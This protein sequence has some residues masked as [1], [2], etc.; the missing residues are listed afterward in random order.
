MPLAFRPGAR[1]R[2]PWP[3]DL[4]LMGAGLMLGRPRGQ[5]GRPGD[6]LV[7]TE[8][9]DLSKVAPT[10]FE[11][12]ATDPEGNR[13]QPYDD[14][15]L[16]F[17]LQTQDA[18]VDRRYGHTLNADVSVPG[19]WLKGP[20]ITTFTPATTDATN[21]VTK[22]FDLGANTY[23]LV[24]RYA[25]LRVSDA[26]WSVSK[27]FGIGIRGRDV[28]TFH[29]NALAAQLAV[30]AIDGAA[31]WHFDGTTWTQFATF[32]SLA[33]AAVGRELYR[34]SDVNLV[35]KV[36]TNADPTNEA[37]WT[38]ANAF[39]VGDKASPIT[40]MFV[41]ATGVL[42]IVKTDG[43]YSLDGAGQDIR[44]FPFL[45]PAPHPDAG[46]GGGAFL[47]DLYLPFR[48]GLYRLA[49]DFVLQEAGPERQH[50][51]AFLAGVRTT[52]FQGHDDLHAYAGVTDETDGYLMKLLPSGVWHGPVSLAFAG[53]RITALWKSTAGAPAS[54]ARLYLGFSDGSLGWFALPNTANPAADPA[55]PFSA[56][57]GRLRVPTF[58]GQ[59]ANDPKA[60]F[61]VTVNGR[62]LDATNFVQLEYKTDPAAGAFTPLNGNFAKNG[63][64]VTFP[65]DTSAVLAELEFVL[66]GAPQ[67]TGAGLHHLWRPVRRPVY[68]FTVLAD[69]GLVRWDNVPLRTGRTE[70][71]RVVEAARDTAGSTTLVL[72]DH[73][74]VQATLTRLGQ[75]Q[76]WDDRTRQWRSGI[77]VRAV[78]YSQNALYGTIDRFGDLTIDGLGAMTVDESA[79]K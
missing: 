19:L 67:V 45:R 18:F 43:I 13:V 35:S 15:S 9:E 29:S 44:Y 71:R 78:H 73:T 77:Q 27:D 12:G 20:G 16:G 39:R 38:A 23:A 75:T 34:A 24:G 14:F 57:D 62:K 70:I 8:T 7:I 4:K 61:A 6:Q 56:A 36:N 46:K 76:G 37:N 79:T 32:T 63:E 53:K 40:R 25:L 42:V 64:R 74:S 5:D 26:S 66:K 1:R 11:Y 41:T 65:P 30:V 47:N 17:G 72:P 21:G 60:L 33:Y 69:D 54:H 58:T 52:A 28:E 51:T 31:D 10:T 49:P 2:A 22:G 3:Y 59:L 55:Y 50:D 48:Q 68:T